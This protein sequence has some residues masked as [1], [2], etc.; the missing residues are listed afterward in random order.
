MSRNEVDE[1]NAAILKRQ[2][3][4]TEIRYARLSLITGSGMRV[5]VIAPWA[6]A[7]TAWV[8][9]GGQVLGENLS[10]QNGT[11]PARWLL[12]LTELGV[13]PSSESC[14]EEH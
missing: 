9:R 5:V 13:K 6:G 4:R 7:G 12:S 8:R 14:L 2:E 11:S 10:E 3:D 1:S